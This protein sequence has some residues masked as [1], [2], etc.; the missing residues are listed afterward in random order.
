MIIR[1]HIACPADKSIAGAIEEADSL[2]VVGRLIQHTIIDLFHIS[3]INIDLLIKFAIFDIDRRCS[4]S[5]AIRDL[6]RAGSRSDAF[7][8]DEFTEALDGFDDASSPI[9]AAATPSE[10]AASADPFAGFDDPAPAT[11]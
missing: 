11:T 6:E 2:G 8:A 10:A 3:R 4:I 7:D 1:L 5:S 9:E